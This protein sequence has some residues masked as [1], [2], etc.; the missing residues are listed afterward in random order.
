MPLRASSRALL[1]VSNTPKRATGGRLAGPFE[2]GEVLPLFV[3]VTAHKML[4]QSVHTSTTSDT[5][6]GGMA[7]LGWV[8]NDTGWET[9]YLSTSVLVRCAA[10]TS[11]IMHDAPRR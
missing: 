6:A 8:E 5:P 11:H 3:S 4:C 10:L 9:W 2:A 7:E 1:G